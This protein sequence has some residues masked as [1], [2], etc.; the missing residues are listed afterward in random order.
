MIVCEYSI[1]TISVHSV[2]IRRRNQ[3]AGCADRVQDIDFKDV[4]RTLKPGMDLAKDKYER[5]FINDSCTGLGITTN[6][7]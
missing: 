1:C 4:K 3:Y 6:E 5:E 7:V 2:F